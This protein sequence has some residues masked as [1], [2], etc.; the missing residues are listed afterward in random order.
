VDLA[1]GRSRRV[2]FAALALGAAMAPPAAGA[3]TIADHLNVLRVILPNEPVDAPDFSLDGLNGRPVRL[4]GL[5][6]KVVFLSFWATWCVPC[7]KEMPAMERLYQAYRERG[8]T[9]VAVN[10][11]ESPA[12]ATAFMNELH[13]TFPAALD[14]K[15]AVTASFA[16]RSLPVTYLVDRDGK[17]LW[18]ALGERAWDG[19]PSR[20]YFDRLLVAGGR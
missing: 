20:G 2:L 19:P 6:G 18:K 9:V 16:V 12:E 5:R 14:R 8:L 3:A 4:K 7:R 15:G 13:L 1:A 10:Y 17:I 11:K